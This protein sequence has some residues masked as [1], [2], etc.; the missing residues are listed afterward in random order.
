MRVAYVDPH[1]VPGPGV[2]ALQIAQNVDAYAR[3]VDH[4]DLVTPRP[5]PTASLDALL[6][7]P[8]HARVRVAH[9]TDYREHWW[10]PSNSNRLFFHAV[11]RWLR[12]ER[13]DAVWVRHLR[14]ARAIL[15]MPDAPPVFF[16]THEVFARTHGEHAPHA[17]RKVARL[18]RLEQRV[19]A[20]SRGI[21]ALTAELADDLRADYRSLAPLLV[22]ADGVD[23][24]L[25][26][27]AR[28]VALGHDPVILYIGSL[29]PW[30]GVDVAIA[31]MRDVARGVLV[32]VG[33]DEPAIAPLRARAAQEGV[34]ERVRFVGAVAPKQ[35][36]DWIAAATLCV[37]PLSNATIAARY[38]SPLKLFE[39]LALGKPVVT[40]DL[41]AIREVVE[42]GKNAWLVACA[43]AGAFAAGINTLLDD[44]AQR[45]ALGV[46][47]LATGIQRT[48]DARVRSIGH[49]MAM[50]VADR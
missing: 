7:R 39:Y 16:E 21:I 26:Q 37:L 43:E 17:R 1:P 35:R 27:K 49:F 10:A 11:R 20:R 5:P 4:I 30:K 2:E 34:V 25:A 6:G 50:R 33:G 13:P 40:T 24:I 38:T 41:P 42:H 8:W 46:A 48:W 32:I 3:A 44:D 15:A 45:R 18:R 29:H 9:T 23:A 12:R 19:Y 31:A 14:C 47:A 28:A 22:A 36:F